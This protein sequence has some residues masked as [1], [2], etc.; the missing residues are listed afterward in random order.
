[1]KLPILLTGFETFSQHRSNPTQALVNR[2]ERVQIEGHRIHT[3]ILPVDFKK[4]PLILEQTFAQ[5]NFC[6]HLSLGL[7]SSRKLL[8]PELIA[9]NKMHCP[10]RPDNAGRTFINEEISSNAP[11]ALESTLPVAAWVE[12]MNEAGHASELSVHGGTYVCNAI[13]Y[14]G[15][16]FSQKWMGL[17]PS[18]FM[19][20]PP[21]QQLDPQSSWDQDKLYRALEFSL[22]YL[23]ENTRPK[24][25]LDLFKF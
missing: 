21:D 13:M 22:Q 8:T 16:R 3:L 4:A 20:I 5:Q 10:N 9:L 14:H 15:L 18:G 25:F 6:F 23:L 1:M 12:A 7:A 2:F 17:T 19:H 24:S 11:L